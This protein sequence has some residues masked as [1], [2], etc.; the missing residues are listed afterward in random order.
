MLS[1]T[2][3][4]DSL[5]LVCYLQLMF[6]M[7]LAVMFLLSYIDVLIYEQPNVFMSRKAHRYLIDCIPKC[8]LN[9][10]FESTLLETIVPMALRGR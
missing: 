1:T 9:N 3:L 4:L 5:H 7:L 10:V 2:F 6:M 8:D